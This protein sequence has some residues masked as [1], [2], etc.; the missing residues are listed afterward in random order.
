[1]R[2]FIAMLTLIL[3][4]L[5]PVLAQVLSSSADSSKKLHALFDEDWQWN[6]EQYPEGA[7]LY[8]DNR[9]ND[10]LTDFSPEAV[11][12]RKAHERAMLDRI[13]KIDRSRLKGQDLISYD[14]FLLDKKLNVEGQ[15]FPAELM[16]IDQMN[17][18]HLTFGQLITN[19]P[20]RN[21]KDYEN[22]LARLAAFPKQI[23]QLIELMKRGIET[24]WVQPPVPLRSLASQIEGQIADDPARSPLFQPFQSLPN[25]LSQPEAARLAAAGKKAIADSFTPAMKKLGSFFKETYLPAA[26]QDIGA[27]SLP[28]GE[29]F[30]QYSIRRQTTTSLTAKQIHEIG[31]KEVARIRREMEDVI[32]KT[33]FK[34]S[35]AEFLTFLRTDPRFYYTRADDLVAGYSHIAK[36]AD[37][38]LPRLFAELPRTPYGVRVIPDYEG[39]AQTTAYYQP[40][41]ADGSRAGYYMLNTYKLDTRPRYEMEALTL[42]EAVPGH[43]LQIAR[44]QELKGLPD[45]RRNAGYTAYVEGWAL[46]AESL[47]TEIGFYTDPYSKFGQLTYEMWRACRLVVDTGM[48]A[49]G[50]TRQRAIDF[51]KENTA[52]TEN[53]IIVEIDRYIVWPAQ[54]LAYKLGALKIKEL[55]ARASK[56]LGPRFDVRKFHNAVL[57]DGPLPLDLLEKRMSEWIADQQ[58]KERK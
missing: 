23:D 10:R 12:R 15:R 16:P 52:K 31:L 37:G 38:Q 46:Y 32:Q 27:S 58:R 3:L 41:A 57:D 18:V 50:W 33:G 28:D 5:A 55:R 2:R 54:A 42:H 19:T 51:M 22:Y 6:L 21:T 26:R 4:T 35:F 36:V 44:A 47:G 13:Q 1:M 11:E 48:H 25:E 9:F 20:F 49:F 53:D 34:G 29:A 17:G 24:R 40:S 7:T 39:P 43:H 14:L 8:G 56:E 30:Y 45:F